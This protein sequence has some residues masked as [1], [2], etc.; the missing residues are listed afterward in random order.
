[1][2][3]VRLH[4]VALPYYE[5]GGCLGEFLAEAQGRAMT[6]RPEPTNDVDVNAICAYDW[7]GRHVGYVAIHDQLAA[8]Q[9]LRGSGRRSLRGRVCEVNAEHKCVVFECSVETMGNVEDLYPQTAYH[10][11]TYTGP[12]LKATQE[13]VTLDYMTDEISERLEERNSWNDAD[14]ENFVAL[15][16]RFC[17]LSKYDLSGEMSDYRRRL[18]LRLQKTKD[19]VL[20]PLVEELNMAY[21][22]AGRESQGGEVLDYWMHLLTAPRSI[23]SLLVHRHEYDLEKVHEQLLEFPEAMYEEWQKN[24]EHFVTKLLY[25]HIPREVLWRFISGIAFY[26]TV[27]AYEQVQECEQETIAERI[28]K[29]PTVEL[30]YEAYQQITALLT[31]TSWDKKA[32]EVLKKMFAQVK[33]QQDRQ[34]QKQDKLADAVEKAANKKTN[35]F[36][37]YPQSGSTTNLGCDQKNSDFKTY[38][39]GAGASE[40]Q[41]MLES[42]KKADEDVKIIK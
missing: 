1:M 14:R 17:A 21:G 42:N 18:C 39:P 13:M 34:E 3:T 26:E 4:I 15:C 8:W 31:G 2:S 25:M 23:K 20:L 29:L 32:T 5:V 9:T 27:K 24:R 19:E 12:V 33:E 28:L 7:Q 11:W 38:L 22:R 16:K 37:V 30:Q 6:L 10:K 36:T 40:E 41:S 35:E